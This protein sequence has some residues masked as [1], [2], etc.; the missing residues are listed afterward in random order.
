MYE[1]EEISVSHIGFAMKRDLKVFV[2][3]CNTTQDIRYHL[4]SPERLPE[5]KTFPRKR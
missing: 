3:H 4:V 1:Q 5:Q 2:K